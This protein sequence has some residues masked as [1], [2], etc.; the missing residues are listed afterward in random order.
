MGESGAFVHQVEVREGEV[1]VFVLTDCPS[2][3]QV[4][5]FNQIDA[6]GEC[7]LEVGYLRSRDPNRQWKSSAI[8]HVSVEL[9]ARW[10]VARA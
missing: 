1:K 9:D 4:E 6:R 2:P 8:R 3:Y 5:L 7:A 10:N